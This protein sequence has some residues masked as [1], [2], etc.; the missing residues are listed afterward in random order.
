MTGLARRNYSV[1]NREDYL[2]RN[3]NGMETCIVLSEEYAEL[4]ARRKF[5]EREKVK[6]IL[7]RLNTEG[8]HYALVG[9]M[10][11]AHHT[12]PRMTQDVDFLVLSEEVERVRQ[13]FAPYYVRGTAVVGIYDFE[14]THFDIITANLRFK[15]AIITNA[16]DDTI[17]DV[18]VKVANVRD[19]ILLKLLAA[20]ER[21]ELPKKMQDRTD[22]ASLLQY[23]IDCISPDDITYI[24]QHLLTS[25]YTREEAEKFR[26]EVEWLNETL[27]AMGLGD[28]KYPLSS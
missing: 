5:M 28:R 13:L 12:I 23:S 25:A 24:A 26:K 3:Q 20:P 15:R 16:I 22:A 4:F 18:P 27:E 9:G 21:P 17:D 7:R 10:A 14:G 6:E 2:F 8:I 11:L 1:E 19:L